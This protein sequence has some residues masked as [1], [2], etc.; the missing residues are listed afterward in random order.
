MRLEG[1][2]APEQRAVQNRL[3]GVPVEPE[4]PHR[5]PELPRHID[6]EGVCGEVVQIALSL[7]IERR[8]I[9][10]WFARLP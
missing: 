2:G 6:A 10:A 4:G 1:S 3:G 9:A 8:H 7:Q 5:S